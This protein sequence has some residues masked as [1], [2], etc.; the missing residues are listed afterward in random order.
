M[1]WDEQR[2]ASYEKLKYLGSV[3]K[4]SKPRYI[5]ENMSKSTI[6]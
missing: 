2:K 5:L 6:R 3:A 1:L 4:F